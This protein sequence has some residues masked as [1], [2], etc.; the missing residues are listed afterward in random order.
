MRHFRTVQKCSDE[1]VTYL[2]ANKLAKPLTL[3]HH[4]KIKSLGVLSK[5]EIARKTENR[6]FHGRRFLERL[7]S[8]Q[9]LT[10]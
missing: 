5:L 10:I 4:I 3:R 2:N 6:R 8:N 9:V 1:I 7:L